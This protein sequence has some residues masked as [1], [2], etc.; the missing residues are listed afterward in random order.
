MGRFVFLIWLCAAVYIAPLFAVGEKT[1]TSGG[2]SGWSA[3][4]MLQNVTELNGIRPSPVL[5]ISSAAQAN[6]D[7]IDMYLSFNSRSARIEDDAGRY[8]VKTNYGVEI[9]D[10]RWSRRGTGSALFSGVRPVSYQSKMKKQAPLVIT[11]ASSEALF[12]PSQNIGDFSIEFFVYPNNLSSGEEILS[13]QATVKGG[14]GDQTNGVYQSITCA[15]ARSRLYWTFEN[16]FRSADGK[17][18]KNISFSSTE[19]LSPKTWS[20][21]LVRFDS[22]SGLLEYLVNGVPQSVVYTSESGRQGG[23]IYTPVSG[24]R[25]ALFLGS[26]FTGLLDEFKITHS[27]V[28]F[29][30]GSRYPAAGGHVETRPIDLGE[31]NSEV[32]KI[33]IKGGRVQFSA[34]T[35]QNEYA[36]DGDIRFSD[37]TQAHFFIRAANSPYDIDRANWQP[38]KSGAEIHSIRGRYVQLAA[39]LY[40][41]ANLDASPYI[42]EITV[43]YVPHNAPLPPENIT[44]I[45]EDGGVTLSWKERRFDSA[46]GYLV[47][48]GTK[49]GEYFGIGAIQGES[50]IDVGRVSSV[51]LD[52]LSNGVL[53]YFAVAAYDDG[54]ATHVGMFGREV[55]ARPL[56]VLE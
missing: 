10:A 51:H 41:S 32:K 38:L 17:R 21:H 39:D 16:F 35:M 52:S 36:K 22:D 48:Y 18:T 56:R 24:E 30:G 37:Q 46:K 6:R 7:D 54:G 15:A 44:A 40:P 19:P 20:H 27:F 26:D 42:E 45:A 53:Y 31:V 47:Y 12:A 34:L 33:D 9:A 25:G 8:F 2:A 14:S 49:K 55:T 3:L 5:L 1:K 11:P 50:P 13:W 23:E 28:E 29:P 43:T 4:S